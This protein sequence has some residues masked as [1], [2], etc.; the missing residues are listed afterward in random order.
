MMAAKVTT[1]QI[2]D[3]LEQIVAE[4]KLSGDVT[5]MRQVQWVCTLLMRAANA[6]GDAATAQ[7]FMFLASRAANK[8]EEQTGD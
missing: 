8:Y 2:Y 4:D 5:S 1:D 6:N 7:R 3:Y